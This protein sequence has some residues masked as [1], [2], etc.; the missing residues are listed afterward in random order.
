MTDSQPAADNGAADQDAVDLAHT[1]FEGARAGDAALLGRYLE[2]GAPANLTN[3]AGDSLLML[4]AYH[5]HADTVQLLLGHGADA[6]AVND[7]GQ[8]P[9]AGAAFKGYA[10]VARVLLEAGADPEAGTPSARAAAEMFARKD[11]LELLG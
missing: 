6:N 7:R 9:L 10:D 1:L 8:T 3:A 4:A 2:A 5:G 11:I